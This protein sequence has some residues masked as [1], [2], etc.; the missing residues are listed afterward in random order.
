MN[1][2][3]Q[4]YE[5]NVNW[6]QDRL[7]QALISGDWERIRKAE[8]ELENARGAVRSADYNNNDE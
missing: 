1:E 8:I 7:E 6:A 5:A 3:D 2:I 4:Q